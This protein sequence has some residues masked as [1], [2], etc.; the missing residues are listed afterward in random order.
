MLHEIRRFRRIRLAIT[1]GPRAVCTPV[2]GAVEVGAG[3]A[4]RSSLVVGGGANRNLGAWDSA[5]DVWRND[6]TTKISTGGNFFTTNHSAAVQD[7]TN[8]T[9]RVWSGSYADGSAVPDAWLGRASGQGVQNGFCQGTV[10]VPDWATF[11]QWGAE[12]ELTMYGVSSDLTVG[13]VPE[14]S[15]YAITAFATTSSPG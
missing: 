7:F 10:S 5:V 12:A 4:N 15:T 2:A 6:G 8:S 3:G 14:P 1:P 11:E 13:G 9:D